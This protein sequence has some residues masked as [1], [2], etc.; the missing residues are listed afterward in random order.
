LLLN[1]G[2]GDF[3][4]A[5][6]VLPSPAAVDTR[7][8]ALGDVDED[9]DLDVWM[10]NF[11]TPDDQLFRNDGSGTFT[12]STSLLPRES[13]LTDGLALA[14]VDEDGDLDAFSANGGGRIDRVYA[15]LSRH[16]ARRGLPRIGKPLLLD[17]NGPPGTAWVLLAGLQMAKMEL[18]FGILWLDPG[19]AVVTQVGPFDGNGSATATFRVNEE[20]SL[21]GLVLHW[22][23]VAG[24]PPRLTN[25]ETTVFT[26]L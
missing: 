3:T 24:P 2:L 12:D 13:D 16:L 9:L 4:G 20:P 7:A 15:N 25:C 14:D 21:V 10:G 5:S 17:L 22:Q 23:A 18:P 1:D 11:F 6:V 8:I 26:D 19:S